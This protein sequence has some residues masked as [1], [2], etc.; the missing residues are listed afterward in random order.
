MYMI[1][2]EALNHPWSLFCL[3]V[4]VQT[5]SLP[6]RLIQPNPI[7]LIAHVLS[8]SCN[9]SSFLIAI[10]FH[11]WAFILCVFLLRTGDPCPFLKGK[12]SFSGDIFLSQSEIW[13]PSNRYFW[14]LALLS[15]HSPPSDF[16]WSCPIINWSVWL[17]SSPDARVASTSS[18]GS[19]RGSKIVICEKMMVCFGF[20]G[21]IFRPHDRSYGHVR[22]KVFCILSPQL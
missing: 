7:I 15:M 22:Q 12:P 10:F 19:S 11:S 1:H 5:V 3:S 16:A 4:N 6:S 21:E 20:N 17:I 8:M 18:F 2:M 9:P 14:G 13:Q